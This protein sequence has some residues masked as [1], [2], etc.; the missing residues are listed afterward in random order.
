VVGTLA[1]FVGG[2]G[3]SQGADCG[4]D[5]RRSDE[6]ESLDFGV[7]EGCDDR[8]DEG[9]DGAGAGLGDDDEAR[10]SVSKTSK[11]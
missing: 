1:E 8:R 4:E 3:N 9:G 5:I 10:S 11:E 7:V 2:E 6:E